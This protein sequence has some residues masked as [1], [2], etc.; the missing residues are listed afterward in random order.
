MTSGNPPTAAAAPLDDAALASALAAT[1]GA[2][3]WQ[4][5][6]THTREAQ[7][8]VIGT[9]DE[10]A[11]AVTSEQARVRVLNDHPAHGAATGDASGAESGAARGWAT[12]TVLAADAADPARLRARL[13]D[14]VFMAGLTDNP[15]YH[16][17]E[18]P[19]GGF[20]VVQTV[21]P[22]LADPAQYEQVLRAARDELERA[23]AAELGVRL[24]SA[25]L[26]ATRETSTLRN[27][28]G[29][30]CAGDGTRVFLDAILIARDGEHEAE[31]HAELGRRRVSDLQIDATIRAYAAYAR[32]ALQAVTPATA[33]GPVVISGP[34]LSDLL[35]PLVFHTSAQATFLGVSRLRPGEMV[36]SEPPRGDR[37]SLATDATYPFGTRTAPCDADGVPAQRVALVEDGALRAYW[38][39][40]RYAQYLDIPAT[41]AIANLVVGLGETATADFWAGETVYEIVEFSFLNPD[42]IS[43]DFTSEIRLGYR[44]DPDGTVTPIKG[45]T[46]SGNLFAALADVRF[47]REPLF[48]G[49]Y[50]GPAAMRFG[51]LSIAGE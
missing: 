21:D 22:A 5:E 24:S 16:L 2:D 39:E 34:S 43:G 23:L 44:H 13:G 25:E 19:A 36:T 33:R 14:A 12:V 46:V 3:E 9:A 1:P 38:A 15:P 42:P 17:P 11:R 27:S 31:V 40:Q 51:A 35:G 26:Y 10:S 30:A 41:G 32:D 18:M 47:A 37:L 4:V 45:G 20:P 8:Y 7:L 48:A 49:N 6:L 28:R 29:L 50:Y